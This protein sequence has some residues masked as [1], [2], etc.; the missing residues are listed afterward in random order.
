M[1]R[2]GIEHGWQTKSQSLNQRKLADAKEE[3]RMNLLG[4]RRYCGVR[5]QCRVGFAKGRLA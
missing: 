1:R 3:L 4:C 5:Q 2:V